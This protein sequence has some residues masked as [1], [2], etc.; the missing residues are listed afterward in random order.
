MDPVSTCLIAFRTLASQPSFS[1]SLCQSDSQILTLVLDITSSHVFGPAMPSGVKPLSFCQVFRARS[2]LGPNAPSGVR[3]RNLW[4]YKTSGSE[5]PDFTVIIVVHCLGNQAQ[6]LQ[7]LGWR[8]RRN[9]FDD[10]VLVHVYDLSGA[11][12]Q[13]EARDLA[14]ATS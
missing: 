13:K 7:R 1:A 9:V 14:L 10:V 11:V 2:V 4:R 8:P 3:P 5:V 12:L 6:D